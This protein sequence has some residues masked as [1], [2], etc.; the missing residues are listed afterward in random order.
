MYDLVCIGASWGGLERSAV[1]SAAPPNG[2]LDLPI[3]I[4][5]HRHPTRP[6]ER[7]QSSLQNQTNRLVVDVED[8]MAI[9]PR[10]TYTSRR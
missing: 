10:P 9:E 1:C 3:V 6:K 7:S 2:T 4:A 5:Q 8:K